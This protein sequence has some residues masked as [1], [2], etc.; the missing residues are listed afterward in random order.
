MELRKVYAETV[1][2]IAMQD[3]SVFVLEADL[4]SA[5][6]TS[7]LAAALGKRYVNLGIMEANMMGVAAGI[8]VAGGVCFVHSFGQFATR[9]AFDQVFVS[10]AY[11]KQHVVIV[12][13]DSG[14]TAE[15]NGGTHMTFEDSG[16]MRVVPQARV[17]DVSDAVQLRYLLQHAYREKGVHYIRMVR[18]EVPSLYAEGTTF[19]RG[20]AVLREGTDVSL[21]ANGIE[22]SEA[23][24]AAELLAAKGL[25]AEV[26]DCYRLKPLDEATV[27]ASAR[28]TKAVV[29]CENHN[30]IN[31]LG[32][33][34]A[35]VLSEQCPTLMRRIGVHD[36]FGQVGRVAY[37]KEVYG[38]TA[39]AI[40]NAVQEL[41]QLS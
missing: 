31:G 24:R 9:R 11:A 4:S 14:V 29:T 12:G 36:Q 30:V 39:E 34:V 32:S 33:A 16:L 26:I 19:E 27:V 18:K 40:V 5:I 28:K 23:L 17:Y 6:S 2:Q 13:S 38:L 1:K 3:D 41:K 7:S 15:H 22:V 25:S 37:L 10:L 21:L 35:E 20:A 8:S